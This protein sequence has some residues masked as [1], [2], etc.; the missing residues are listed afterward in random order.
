MA[1]YTIFFAAATLGY[2]LALS[3]E[4]PRMRD[5]DHVPAQSSA[6]TVVPA[7]LAMALWGFADAQVQAQAYWQLGALHATGA[8]QARAVGFFKLVQ[9]AGWCAGF[10]LSPSSRLAPV[11]QLA[12]TAACSVLGLAL[13]ELPNAQKPS[14][15]PRGKHRQLIAAD[16]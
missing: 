4:L 6:W 2:L 5:P 14:E 7:A 12:A 3:L 15:A 16:C 8:A 9:S 13:L 11:L 10:A 1:G